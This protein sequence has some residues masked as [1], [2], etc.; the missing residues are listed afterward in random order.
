MSVP[1]CVRYA[2][3]C[4]GLCVWLLCR[5]GCLLLLLFFI[6]F[7]K[8]PLARKPGREQARDTWETS[9]GAQ[10]RVRARQNGEQKAD[11]WE[12]KNKSRRSWQRVLVVVGAAGLEE[13]GGGSYRGEPKS[14]W[15]CDPC[16]PLTSFITVPPAERQQKALSLSQVA[17]QQRTVRKEGKREGSESGKKGRRE[18]RSGDMKAGWEKGMIKVMGLQKGL[19]RK[20]DINKGDTQRKKHDKSPN[21]N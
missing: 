21:K 13:D 19:E 2:Y 4:E 15:Q 11:K 20:G 12:R 8:V 18:A 7:L 17:W 14:M 16:L 6:M 1:V 10:F 9:Q 3:V 5:E